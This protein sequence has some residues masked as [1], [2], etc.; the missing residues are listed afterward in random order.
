MVVFRLLCQQQ[1]M[2][3]LSIP[4]AQSKLYTSL[5]G[6]FLEL[7]M[8]FTIATVLY[9][10][11]QTLQLQP[12]PELSAIQAVL[13]FLSPALIQMQVARGVI[14]GKV[15]ETDDLSQ[16]TELCFATNSDATNT[17]ATLAKESITAVWTIRAV[18]NNVNLMQ[19]N[20]SAIGVCWIHR[21]FFF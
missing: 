19:V 20:V 17:T 21:T 18:F 11:F 7:A 6:I 12:F 4:L 1:Q 5:A 13:S 16:G 2:Q 3:T 10:P 14:Y 8:F 9:M 15:N